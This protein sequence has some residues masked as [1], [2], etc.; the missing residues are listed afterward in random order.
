MLTKAILIVAINPI[1]ARGGGVNL[2]PPL[3]PGGSSQIG[4]NNH[5]VLPPTKDAAFTTTTR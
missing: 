4:L 3:D 2:T 5:G 1:S